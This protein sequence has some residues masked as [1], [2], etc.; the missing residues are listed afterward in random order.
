[1]GESYLSA[2]VNNTNNF[3]ATDESGEKLSN[4]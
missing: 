2:G 1:M 3:H 4:T